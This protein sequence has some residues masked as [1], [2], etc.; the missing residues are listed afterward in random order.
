MSGLPSGREW[1]KSKR[2]NS[3]VTPVNGM[4]GT[5]M[6]MMMMMMMTKMMVTINL[7]PNEVIL[8]LS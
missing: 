5:I 4:V 8:I 6:M 3:H 2:F 7:K 1:S